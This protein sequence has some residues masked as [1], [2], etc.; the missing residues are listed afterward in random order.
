MLSITT[1]RAIQVAI[2]AAQGTTLADRLLAYAPQFADLALK[3]QTK[4][5]V[6][7]SG[8]CFLAAATEL[9]FSPLIS[10]MDGAQYGSDA[11]HPYWDDLVYRSGWW[12]MTICIGSTYAFIVLISDDGEGLDELQAMCREFAA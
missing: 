2:E 10:P 8:D 11:F 5:I 12:V 6:I 1:H 3:D 9:L 4:L 7:E